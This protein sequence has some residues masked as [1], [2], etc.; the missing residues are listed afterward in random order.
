MTVFLGTGICLAQD[1]VPNVLSDSNQKIKSDST[2][3]SPNKENIPQ[4]KEIAIQQSKETEQPGSGQSLFLII[5]VIVL[6]ILVSFTN[7]TLFLCV[8]S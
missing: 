7:A 4:V 3:I 6:A 5:A 1:T 8:I 2:Q